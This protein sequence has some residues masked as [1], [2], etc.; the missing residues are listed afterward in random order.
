M[1]HFVRFSHELTD[2]LVYVL[3][4]LGFTALY[5]IRA[6]KI[7]KNPSNGILLMLFETAIAVAWIIFAGGFLTQTLR[8]AD[9]L[10][11]TVYGIVGGCVVIIV[12][13][14]MLKQPLI[15]ENH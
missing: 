8:M 6:R 14:S 15:A 13:Q 11:V 10:A 3:L 4:L 1:D 2:N 7:T 12:T 9:Q 5:W